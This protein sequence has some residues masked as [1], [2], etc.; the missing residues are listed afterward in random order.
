MIKYLTQSEGLQYVHNGMS[1]VIRHSSL[2]IYR[3]DERG[4]SLS[5]PILPLTLSFNFF[6]CPSL[7]LSNSPV[8]G[9]FLS[10]FL[11][12]CVFFSA[13]DCAALWY[14]GSSPR[15]GSLLC[16]LWKS[17]VFTSHFLPFL[18]KISSRPSYLH[19][20]GFL[21]DGEEREE[22]TEGR[23]FKVCVKFISPPVIFPFLWPKFIILYSALFSFLFQPLCMSNDS[24][25][26][27]SPLM[28]FCQFAV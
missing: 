20:P 21:W 14:T 9:T 26:F 10:L 17:K 13:P 8:P 4:H 22:C 3:G 27:V 12:V 6:L 11:S 19:R 1:A 25:T 7:C 16:C 5:P 2:Q 24:C 15:P 23:R 28:A 18:L